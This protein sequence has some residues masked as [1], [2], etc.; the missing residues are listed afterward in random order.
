MIPNTDVGAIVYGDDAFDACN[1]SHESTSLSDMLQH[2]P[3]VDPRFY[4]LDHAL[5][6][7]DCLSEM[8]EACFHMLHKLKG[9]MLQITKIVL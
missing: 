8:H 7:I 3:Q 9:S 4:V 5:I 1:L 2:V 6:V